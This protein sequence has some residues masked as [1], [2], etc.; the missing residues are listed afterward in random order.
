MEKQS[1]ARAT[2][3][4]RRGRTWEGL[5]DL[6]LDVPVQC[7]IGDVGSVSGARTSGEHPEDTTVPVEDNRARVAVGRE[8]TGHAAVGEGSDFHR[9]LPDIVLIVDAGERLHSR[10]ATNGGASCQTVLDDERARFSVGVEVQ[11]VV[12]LVGLYDAERL[13]KSVLRVLIVGLVLGLRKHNLAVVQRRKVASYGGIYN[14][15]SNL[16]T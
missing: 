10:D 6:L 16:P 4:P 3:R 8:R 15:Q 2:R 7:E 12:D 14:G 11:E 13:Q 9:C 1:V 5:L